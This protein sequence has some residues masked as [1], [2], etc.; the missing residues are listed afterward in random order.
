MIFSQKSLIEEYVVEILD[1]GPQSGPDIHNEINANL[2]IVT[3]QAIYR[4]LR[5][6]I[7]EEVII[8]QSSKYS[9]SR[10][11]L[12]KIK[13]FSNRHLSEQT[14]TETTNVL[15]FENGE[16]VTYSFKNPFLLDITWGHIYDLVYESIPT[17]WANLNYHPHEWLF[18]SR[19]ES[20]RFWLNRFVEDKKMICFS[21]GGTSFLDKTFQ[22]EFSSDY[23]KI[24]LGESYGL[25]P[26]Q[27]LAVV[28]DFV[29]EVT[30]AEA[31][32][33]KV[34][35]FFGQVDSL[36]SVDQER[37]T[38]ISKMR[39]RSKLKISR[40]KKKAEMWRRKFKQDFYIPKPY[41]L[42]DES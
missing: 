18:M 30:T 7:Q 22:K 23:V 42:F 19:P 20:E 15:E 21:I 17:H 13:Q 35:E 6:L 29:F 39:Y 8:K 37:I 34:Q 4:A 14:V 33:L 16:S 26:N 28:G 31:F 27:Y 5:G 32:E 11:W 12:Q 10:I 24:N 1:R 41:Y 38:A 2:R 9:L 36:K 40:N 25:K 3:K